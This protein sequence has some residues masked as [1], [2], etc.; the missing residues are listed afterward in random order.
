[1]TDNLQ[2]NVL[3]GIRSNSVLAGQYGGSRQGVAEGL[4]MSDFTKQLN[5]S[6]TQLGLANSANTAAQ[7]AGAYENGQN[8]AL[9]AAQGLSGQQYATAFKNNDTQNMSE[10]TNVNMV[11]NLL[12]TNTALRQQT[13][14]ANADRQQQ[15]NL[16]N[17]GQSQQN[18]Q[19]NAGLQQQTNLANQQ[20]Q[21]STNAQN[22]GALLGGAGLL[23]GLLGQVQG[24]VNQ[25]D[26]WALNRAQGVNSLLA[27]YL[28]ANSSTTNTQPLYSNPTGNA[29]A[30][31]GMGAQL[32]GLF[33]GS[34]SGQFSG[35]KMG[36]LA[37]LF[38]GK[39][40]N[41]G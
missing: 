14:Q 39:F 2:R 8:R 23:S 16:Y 32:G 19:F 33:G 26:N 22:N 40:M 20:A 11:N 41:F 31:L 3:P 17:A 4:A 7:L 10:L 6:N 29:I 5:N 25:N 30:G 27:P 34:T 9:S 13:S 24:T 1:M 18:N 35:E 36:G 38:S 28:G 12:G 37:D 15:A 21:L